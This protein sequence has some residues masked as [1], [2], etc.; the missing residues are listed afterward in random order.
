MLDML[1]GADPKQVVGIERNKHPNLLPA[2]TKLLGRKCR[3]DSRDATVWR[4]RS[5]PRGASLPGSERH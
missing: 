3:E 4:D 5:L 2:L 1:S